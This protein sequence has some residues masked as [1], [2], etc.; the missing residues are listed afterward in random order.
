MML[1]LRVK[2]ALTTEFILHRI[3]NL[4][5][6]SRCQWSVFRCLFLPPCYNTSSSNGLARRARLESDWECWRGTAGQ[7]DRNRTASPGPSTSPNSSRFQTLL[8]FWRTCLRARSGRWCPVYLQTPFYQLA[9]F[10]RGSPNDT[11]SNP[12]HP[13]TLH[14]ITLLFAGTSCRS[15]IYQT[16]GFFPL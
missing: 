6:Y 2:L 11:Y 1:S 5:V 8:W 4:Q 10:L 16:C 12:S 9:R 15:R 7:P 3:L 14:T 13:S